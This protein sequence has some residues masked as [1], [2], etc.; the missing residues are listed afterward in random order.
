[1]YR[2]IRALA[3]V[4]SIIQPAFAQEFPTT[5][6]RMIVGFPPGGGA[7]LTAR[8]VSRKLN[9]IWGRPVVVENRPGAGGNLAAAL[10]ARAKPD[11]YTLIVM[12]G[13]AAPSLYPELTFD[14]RTQFAPIK[15]AGRGPNVL[16]LHPSVPAS[17]VKELIALA[18]SQPGKLNYAS[19]GVGITPHLAAELFRK[20]TNTNLVHVP[21]KGA[22]PAV[23]DLV[24]GHVDLMIVS[25]PSVLGQ[26][27]SNRLKALGV[28][29]LQRSPMLP[30]VP[31]LDEAGVPGYE[32]YQWWGVLAPAGTPREI[33]AKLNSAM[34]KGLNAADIRK[35]LEE[36]GAE[37][38]A[39]SPS[40]F[41]DFFQK[42]LAKWDSLI[43][44]A[45]K[46]S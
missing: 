1:M 24:G 23:S 46:G 39:N 14:L 36:E 40:E 19:S 13:P 26:I 27:Q 35:R 44:P 16:V 20:M 4:F 6:V 9:E 2:W 30:H 18:R 10:V 28:T 34:V 43:S 7:D 38:V 5:L 15:L 8:L 25:I 12:P 17:N 21:Y 32:S 41:G 37:V 22:G 29:S 33:I 11:G 45:K 31:S 42:E 3:V